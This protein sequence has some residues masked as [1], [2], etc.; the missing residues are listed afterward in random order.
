M[1]GYVIRHLWAVFGPVSEEEEGQAL[2]EYG[3]IL[4]LIA[5]AAIGALVIVGWLLTDVFE[6]I[7]QRLADALPGS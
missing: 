6:E 3:L 1:L 4:A 2:T 7:Q 5:I